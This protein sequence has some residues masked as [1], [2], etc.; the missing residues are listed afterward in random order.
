MGE[1]AAVPGEREEDCGPMATIAYE[2]IARSLPARFRETYA[3]GRTRDIG[4]REAMS[5]EGMR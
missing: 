3:I 4:L 1:Y 5:P 2:T